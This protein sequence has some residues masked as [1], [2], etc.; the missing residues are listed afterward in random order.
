MY[1]VSSDDVMI[2]GGGAVGLATALALLESGRNVRVIEARHVGAGSSHGNCGTIT[3]SHAAPLAQ[4]GMVQTALRMM[5]QPDA[6]LYIKP[7]VD[8]V[9]WR[10]LLTFAARCNVRDFEASARAK[11][12]LLNDSR[13]RLTEWVHKYALE[14]EFVESGEDYV[15]RDPRR[16][17]H[18]MLEAPILRELGVQVDVYEGRDYEAREPALKPG[19]AGAI[20]FAG[21]AALRPDKYVA[22]LARTLR[23]LGGEIVEGCAFEGIEHERDGM[24]VRT[25]G[26]TFNARDLVCALG[27]WTPQLADAIGLRAL[28]N[29][30]QPGKG[31]S[32]TYDPPALVPKHPLVLRERQAVSYT[33]LTLPTI[34]LV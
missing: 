32:I 21:D 34:L 5:L 28:R 22:E 23:A 19:V 33:H 9:L 13:V 27:A 24:R 7:R 26:G 16:L 15:F 3:P 2:A 4:P 12:A 30:M 25:S 31:Y 1:T 14:C 17:E 18:D 20:R 11:G 10:W 29:A 6:P 8:P